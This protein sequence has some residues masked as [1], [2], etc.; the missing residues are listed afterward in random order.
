MLHFTLFAIGSDFTVQKQEE[1]TVHLG[2]LEFLASVSAMYCQLA[3][4]VNPHSVY[5]DHIPAG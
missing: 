3:A 4:F 1:G 2:L 5:V